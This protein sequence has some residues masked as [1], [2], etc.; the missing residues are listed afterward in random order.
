VQISLHGRL[1]DWSVHAEDWSVSCAGNGRDQ[2]ARPRRV[3]RMRDMGVEDGRRDDPVSGAKMGCEP[4]GHAEADDA[5]VALAHGAGNDVWQVAS[6]VAANDQHAG[7]GG[8]LGFKAHADKGND[9][10]VM[11]FER[12]TGDRAELVAVIQA[13]FGENCPG[14]WR[15]AG[16]LSLAGK[17]SLAGELSL[18]CHEAIA[19]RQRSGLNHAPAEI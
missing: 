16:E 2:T 3:G 19:P 15:L 11:S 13:W 17:S 7:S 8:D 9:D 6:G 18:R 5:A 14:A 10:A 4:A 12:E 1:G